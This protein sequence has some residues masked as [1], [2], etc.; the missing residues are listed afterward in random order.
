MC[1][2]EMDRFYIDFRRAL[3]Q[4]AGYGTRVLNRLFVRHS[5]DL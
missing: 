3:K 1:E 4:K 5:D 2:R